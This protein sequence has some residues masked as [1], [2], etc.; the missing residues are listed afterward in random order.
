[1][2]GQI[3]VSKKVRKRKHHYR[4]ACFVFE[5]SQRVAATALNISAGAA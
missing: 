1:M 3:E 5:F 4:C 2:V